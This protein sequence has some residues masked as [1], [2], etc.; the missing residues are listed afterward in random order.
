MPH[1]RL[2]ALEAKLHPSGC[3]QRGHA[4]ILEN[5]GR[6]DAGKS[7]P[8]VGWNVFQNMFQ[9]ETT[10][11]AVSIKETALG[12]KEELRPRTSLPPSPIWVWLKINLTQVLVH[13]STYPG[14]ILVPVS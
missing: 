1:T 11:G 8:G 9:W 10:L 6:G 3:P 13:V 5:N 2:D 4:K 14:S 12:T 7:A